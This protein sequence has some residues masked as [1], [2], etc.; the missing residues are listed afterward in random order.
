MNAL[1]ISRG[2]G[3]LIFRYFTTK[4]GRAIRYGTHDSIVIP[5]PEDGRAWVRSVVAT[6]FSRP[7]PV[8]S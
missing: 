7:L 4:R 3:P 1:P 5:R 8:L 2:G 6:V